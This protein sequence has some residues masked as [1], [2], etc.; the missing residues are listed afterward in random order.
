MKLFEIKNN[1]P[2]VTTEGIL[3]FRE[4]YDRDTSTDKSRFFQELEYVY[5][6]TDYRSYY[7]SYPSEEQE[8]Q[9]IKDYIKIENWKPDEV[10][11]RAIVKYKALQKTESLGLL[12]DARY[13]LEKIRGYYK[14]I[15]F[16]KRDAKGNQ[17]FKITDVTRSIGD[18]S[19]MIE[20]LEKLKEKVVREEELNSKTRGGAQGGYFEDQ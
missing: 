15:D 13:A 18:I 16:N 9:V 1:Q 8:Q 2:I 17:L 7:L 10:V 14:S 11:K 20:S 19:K 12:E 4:L 3:T 6:L 5:F